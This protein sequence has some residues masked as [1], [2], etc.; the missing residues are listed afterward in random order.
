MTKDQDKDKTTMVLGILDE[1]DN[2]E[3]PE[4]DPSQMEF[5]L[6]N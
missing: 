2:T 1:D 5:V 6:E 4:N 3:T